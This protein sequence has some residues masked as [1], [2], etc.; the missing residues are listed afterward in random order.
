[1]KV[2]SGLGDVS[3]IAAAEKDL[4]HKWLFHCLQL[5]V[6]AS[7]AADI[8]SFTEVLNLLGLAVLS[9]PLL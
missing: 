1:M 7:H 8:D 3:G 9:S 4:Q 5:E 6:P 2:C